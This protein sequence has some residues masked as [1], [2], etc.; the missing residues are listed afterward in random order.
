MMMAPS[1]GQ[2][3]QQQQQSGGA[4]TAG[5]T[6]RASLLLPV[7]G[8]GVNA[9]TAGSAGGCNPRVSVVG[10][11]N[12]RASIG[13]GSRAGKGGRMSISGVTWAKPGAKSAMSMALTA[14]LENGD[15]HGHTQVTDR[16]MIPLKPE[17]AVTIRL[18]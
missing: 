11:A 5:V 6:G 4:A 10:M 2:L 12:P 7:G 1:A 14:N 8:G 18:W 3:Q 9:A 17:P 13:G 15:D 16:N